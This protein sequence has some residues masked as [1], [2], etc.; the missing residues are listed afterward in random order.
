MQCPRKP[1]RARRGFNLVELLMALA[2]SAALLSATMVSLDASFMAYQTTTEV[3]ST[4]TIG[5][6][7]VNRL[8]TLIRTGSEFA[9]FPVDPR[10]TIVES[11]FIQFRTGPGGDVMTIQWIDSDPVL[12]DNSLYIEIDGT[13]HLLL[14]GVVAQTDAD[15]D[16]VM[17][18]TLEY[19]RGLELYR[20]TIDLAI[21]PDDNMNV[22]L[23]GDR[24]EIIR[25]VATAMP[26]TT[27]FE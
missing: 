6:L 21:Q 1:R 2:I 8:L 19:E 27:A 15:G 10:D 20:A 18:F 4:H 11:D 7:T 22:D 13:Q 5:R 12:Q 24:Q 23:D 17:P 3:A 16:P 14:E 25:L 9:P 26:R